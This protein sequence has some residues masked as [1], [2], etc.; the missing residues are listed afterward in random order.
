MSQYDGMKPIL[1]FSG[2]TDSKFLPLINDDTFRSLHQFFIDRNGGEPLVPKEASSRKLKVQT[3][4]IGIIKFLSLKNNEGYDEFCQTISTALDL[5][6]RKRSFYSTY[7][8]ENV[9]DYLN[10]KTDTLI[11]KENF[12]RFYFDSQIEWWKNKASKRYDSLKSD[13]RLRTVLETWNTNPEDI[14]IIR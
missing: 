2:L 10:L 11:K 1:R 6:Q 12:D 9:M 7:G 5:T 13:G 8:Y 4:M 14:D 3:K